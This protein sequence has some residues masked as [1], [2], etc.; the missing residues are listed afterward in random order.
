MLLGTYLFRYGHQAAQNSGGFGMPALYA[1]NFHLQE[2]RAQDRRLVEDLSASRAIGF[3]GAPH[4]GEPT[5]GAGPVSTENRD[6]DEVIEA[7]DPILAEFGP[8][9]SAR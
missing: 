5:R 8:F 7:E 2:S 3:H 1:D 9:R 4:A 6:V